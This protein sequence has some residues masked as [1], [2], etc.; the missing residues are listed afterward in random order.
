[1]PLGLTVALAA[2]GVCGAVA[3]FT[4]C[5]LLLEV[6]AEALSKLD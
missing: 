2:L 6:I 1:M 3:F 5:L 4:L